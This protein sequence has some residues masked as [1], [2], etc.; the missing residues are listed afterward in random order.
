MKVLHVTNQFWPSIGGIEKIVL[1][2]CKESRKIGIETAVLCLNHLNKSGTTLSASEKFEGIPIIRIPFLNLHFYKPAII[3][4]SKIKKYDIVHVHGVSALS[5]FILTTKWIHKKPVVLSTHG[6]IFHTPTIPALKKAYFFGLQKLLL[7]EANQIVAVSSID[8]EL[9][10]KISKKV[11]IIEN[12]V[13]LKRLE[14]VAKKPRKKKHFFV[15]WADFT[16]QANQ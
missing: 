9:F 15:C 6:G 8:S 11:S 16:Q 2:L 3:P 13:D 14:A 5:D 10:K 7:R 4:L 12:G 1:D